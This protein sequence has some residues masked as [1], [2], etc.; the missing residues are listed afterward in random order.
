MTEF[1]APSRLAPPIARSYAGLSW[2]DRNRAAKRV[3][4]IAGE[5]GQTLLALDH[6]TLI[7]HPTIP[8]HWHLA[9]CIRAASD[10]SLDRMLDEAL[11]RLPA[12][13]NTSLNLSEALRQ[14]ATKTLTP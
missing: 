14:W 9:Q 3:C 10:D 6:L 13:Q 8:P 7:H 1:K 5:T 11:A 4:R 2:E 12:G